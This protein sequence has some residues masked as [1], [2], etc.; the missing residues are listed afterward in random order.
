MVPDASN[1]H[2]SVILC[3]AIKEVLDRET[4]WVSWKKGGPAFGGSHV[5]MS[6]TVA[7]MT[8]ISGI[9]VTCGT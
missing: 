5:V 1:V 9:V 4:T 6:V 7:G 2:R 3:R 8:V